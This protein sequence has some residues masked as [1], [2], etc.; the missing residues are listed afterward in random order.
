M[1]DATYEFFSIVRVEPTERAT[2]RMDVLSSPITMAIKSDLR[3]R[4]PMRSVM[5]CLTATPW[6]APIVR[7]DWR[8]P[9]ETDGD[10]VPFLA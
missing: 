9:K 3:A 7:R 2:A 6:G 8:N 1:P 4:L 5:L 10:A